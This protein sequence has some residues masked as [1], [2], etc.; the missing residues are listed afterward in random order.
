MG[1]LRRNLFVCLSIVL[2]SDFVLSASVEKQGLS[3]SAEKRTDQDS[4]IDALHKTHA[5]DSLHSRGV[6]KDNSISPGYFYGPPA[7]EYGSPASEYGLPASEYG[8]PVST[9]YGAPPSNS[10]GA[11]SAPTYGPPSSS[12]GPPSSSY[13][14]P[15]FSYHYGPPSYSRPVNVY[16]Y[17]PAPPK[18]PIV[19]S[20]PRDEH[21]LFDKFKFK[22]D[23]FTIGKILIKLIIFKKIVKFIALICLLLFLPRLQTKQMN[24]VD[25]LAGGDESEESAEEKRSFDMRQSRQ[26]QINEV[27][28]FAMTAIESFTDKHLIKCGNLS[29]IPCRFQSMVDNIDEKYPYERIIEMFV[30]ISQY[31]LYPPQNPNKMRRKQ[32][33]PQNAAS[34]NDV[35]RTEENMLQ[36]EQSY[37][38]SSTHPSIATTPQYDELSFMS[39]SSPSIDHTPDI[40]S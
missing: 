17:G 29:D 3:A 18:F 24:I 14:P 10:Y 31:Y 19:H 22:L 2:L 34:F 36:S 25:M 26:K 1:K 30:P 35:N 38:E 37:V 5:E 7:S 33:K 27:S 20:A 4:Y 12:Y 13:G 28:R 39:S 16:N 21:W 8:L 40:R 32:L 11:S 6:Y 23:L 9:E 15:S